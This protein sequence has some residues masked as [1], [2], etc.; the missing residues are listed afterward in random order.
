M[1]DNIEIVIDKLV[2]VMAMVLIIV[3]GLGLLVFLGLMIYSL[4]KSASMAD[5]I[6]DKI[7]SS[8]SFKKQVAMKKYDKESDLVQWKKYRVI[9][10]KPRRSLEQSP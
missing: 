3:C 2:E 1:K 9:R 7:M 4:C 10:R 6:N 8:P 5:E